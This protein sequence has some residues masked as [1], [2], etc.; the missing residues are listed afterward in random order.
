MLGE[1]VSVRKEP[2][3][4]SHHPSSQRQVTSRS[5]SLSLCVCVCR[6]VCA[7]APWH[8]VVADCQLPE[9]HPLFVWFY[10]VQSHFSIHYLA[11][12]F[13][14]SRLFPI[15]NHFRICNQDFLPN[16][17]KQNRRHFI[18]F[19]LFFFFFYS[20][21]TMYSFYQLSFCPSFDHRWISREYPC[22][23]MYF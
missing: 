2:L 12:Q 15:V 20:R 13:N 21:Q 16:L 6:C 18:L 11:G 4:S 19:S 14:W 9:Q 1:A 23:F 10:L 5:L 7:L 8:L 3:D 17:I 22:E